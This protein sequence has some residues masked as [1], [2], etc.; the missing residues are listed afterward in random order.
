MQELDGERRG[1]T[2]YEY[3]DFLYHADAN[4]P[5]RRYVC[6]SR[7]SVNKCNV[8]VLDKNG[9]VQVRRKHTHQPPKSL[10]THEATQKI[11][12]LARNELDLS[13]SDIMNRVFV[14]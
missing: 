6:A 11:K 5:G 13:P 4:Y 9:I 7:T 1:T 2:K 3:G 10:K 12:I 8:S 14:E